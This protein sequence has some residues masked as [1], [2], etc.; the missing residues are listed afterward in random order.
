MSLTLLWEIAMWYRFYTGGCLAGDTIWAID[1]EAEGGF[2]AG[3]KLIDVLAKG[4]VPA[5]DI[6]LAEPPR[7]LNRLDVFVWQLNRE[8]TPIV[9]HTVH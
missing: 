2:S 9:F 1:V 4:G 6:C 7:P 8:R 5:T 3:A